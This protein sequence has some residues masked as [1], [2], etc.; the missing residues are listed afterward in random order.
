MWSLK[1]PICV[2]GAKRTFTIKGTSFLKYPLTW[3]QYLSKIFH[4]K[5]WRLPLKNKHFMGIF[6]FSMGFILYHDKTPLQDRQSPF[7]SEDSE[8]TLMLATMVA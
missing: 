6:Y 1:T 5:Q 3:S 7:Q 8:D 4:K 2:S